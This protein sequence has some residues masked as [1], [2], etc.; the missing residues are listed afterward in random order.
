MT[1]KVRGG[2]ED[3]SGQTLGHQFH[4]TL[5]VS[6]S[7]EVQAIE[8]IVIRKTKPT[9]ITFETSIVPNILFFNGFGDIISACLLRYTPVIDNNN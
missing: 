5:V 2:I 6:T 8:T 4:P 9:L 3:Y 1:V 7:N